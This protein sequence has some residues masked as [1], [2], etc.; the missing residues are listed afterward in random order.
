MCM[1]L[2]QKTLE[3][4]LADL[5]L[6]QQ[7]EK[8]AKEETQMQLYAGQVSQL[9][10]TEKSLRLQ[11]A[12]DEERFQQFQKK[13]KKEEEGENYL[14]RVALPRFPCPVRCPW[15]KNR[16]CDLSPASDSSLAGDSFSP[17]EETPPFS[18]CTVHTAQY[19][20]SYHTEINSVCR[21]GPDALSKSN[22]VFEAFK[23]EME[24]MAKL[25][26]ELKKENEFLKSKCEKSDIALVKLIEELLCDYDAVLIVLFSLLFWKRES[27]K[28]Q[29][30][31]VKNQKEKLESLCRSLQA[32]RK[33]NLAKTI[34]DPGA[35]QVTP[36]KEED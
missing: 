24:K 27:M 15:A 13:E 16:P 14:V 11:L 18:V 34:S 5:K 20:I 8:S 22:E 9:M 36:S 3:L 1:Q 26:K 23:Q 30:E 19:R 25:I 6:K 32:E 17:H 28:K 4:Q 35:V 29:L 12:A 7:E 33:H 21:Y 10:T 2:Q 31:K